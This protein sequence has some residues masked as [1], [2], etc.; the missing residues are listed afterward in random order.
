MAQIGIFD[1]FPYTS[2]AFR[3]CADISWCHLTLNDFFLF[4]FGD[5][6]TL[7]TL[8]RLASEVG[9]EQLESLE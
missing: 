1:C 2:S 3:V 7:E 5:K 9:Q 4:C 6:A 8:D